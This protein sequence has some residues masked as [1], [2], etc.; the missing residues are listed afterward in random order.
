MSLRSADN[1]Q[2]NICYTWEIILLQDI[3]EYL[4]NL[5]Q[6]GLRVQKGKRV[7]Q[8]EEW[9]THAGEENI[10]LKQ[11]ELVNYIQV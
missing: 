9:F 2:H 3:L 1:I 7:D 10:V 4:E 8:R 11:L 6:Q 5:D